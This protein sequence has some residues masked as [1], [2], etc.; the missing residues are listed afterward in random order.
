MGDDGYAEITA[1]L[2][3]G[4]EA[5]TESVRHLLELTALLSARID[6][7]DRRLTLLTGR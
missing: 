6:A 4:I 3:R 5:H 7:L 2:Q 1:E